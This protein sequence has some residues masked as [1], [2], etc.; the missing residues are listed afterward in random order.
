MPQKRINKVKVPNT[1]GGTIRCATKYMFSMNLGEIKELKCD[2]RK[3]Y[4]N[5]ETT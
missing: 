5:L 2:E 4:E 3:F 1:I